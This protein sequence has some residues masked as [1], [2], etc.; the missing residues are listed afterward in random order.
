MYYGTPPIVTNGLVLHLDAA[1]TLSYQSG[2][3]T[4]NDL[5]GNKNNGTLINGPTFNS[6][7][8]GS[9]VF[10]GVNDYASIN[11]SVGSGNFTF[12]IWLRRQSTS[13]Q[14]EFVFGRYADSTARGCMFF[15]LNNILSFSIAAAASFDTT[16][17]MTSPV[18]GSSWTNIVASANRTSNVLLYRDGLLDKQANISAQQ[19]NIP[20]LSF[21]GSANGNIWF[22]NANLGIVQ[23]YNR[24]LT[25]T[26]VLQNYNATK[27]RFN[28]T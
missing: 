1:N 10:D 9:L 2:S 27:S 14:P 15:I 8:G 21:I 19:G 18:T 24:A 16:I 3:T 11:T 28:L 13:T 5:S 7:N 4:W 12:N 25:P 22:L 26:E 17:S 6:S 23:V 20:T